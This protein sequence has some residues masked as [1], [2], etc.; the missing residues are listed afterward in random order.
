MQAVIP[1]FG[2]NFPDIRKFVFRWRGGE[3][4]NESK[5][6]ETTLVGK[7]LG[8]DFGWVAR[9][10]GGE[11]GI[12]VSFYVCAVVGWSV[13]MRKTRSIIC[14]EIGGKGRFF[15]PTTLLEILG[16]QRRATM[17]HGRNIFCY[18]LLFLTTKAKD[19]SGKSLGKGLGIALSRKDQK[20]LS[21]NLRAFCDDMCTKSV[22]CLN[23]EHLFLLW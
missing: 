18:F 10:V 12:L 2:E 16:W 1:S 23:R 13:V 11:F 9:N 14:F 21:Q 5:N 17:T 3:N 8:C 6:P 4:W 19:E 7:W 15:F 20:R 22:I